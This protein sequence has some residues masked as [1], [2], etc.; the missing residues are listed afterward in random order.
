VYTGTHSD[1][2]AAIAAVDLVRR[3]WDHESRPSG[4]ELKTD[5]RVMPSWSRLVAFDQDADFATRKPSLDVDFEPDAW[6]EYLESRDMVI[7]QR[8]S[9]DK[10]LVA[11]WRESKSG[12]PVEVRD[13][14]VVCHSCAGYGQKGAILYASRLLA[15]DSTPHG[16]DDMLATMVRN[17]THYEHAEF[18]LRQRVPPIVRDSLLKLYY[19]A[20]LVKYHG[21]TDPR[22]DM[23]FAQYGVIRLNGVW[24]DL[25]GSPRKAALM[26]H[27]AAALPATHGPDGVS[28]I[29]VEKFLDSGDLT[30]CG[31]PT[32]RPVFGMR[33]GTHHQ[34]ATD[35]VPRVVVATAAKKPTY[36]D[37][38]RR[39]ATGRSR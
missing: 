11:P 19:R 36:I 6:V 38:S 14:C 4:V 34:P 18:V 2:R 13:N 3:L 28:M 25:C 16:N 39:K 8:Y 7:G 15:D 23:V 29:R 27:T 33:I 21:D 9:H 12:K 26:K 32:V 30:S 22:V 5:T 24:G 37:E 35:G 20:L 1:L 31:Y 10:C 17:F